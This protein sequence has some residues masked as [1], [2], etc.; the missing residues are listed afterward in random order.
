MT[1]PKYAPILEADEVRP[2]SR[3]APPRAWTPHR[4]GEIRPGAR[5]SG[6]GLGDPGPDQGYALGLA[7]RF[8]DRLVLGAGERRDD[9]LAGAVA[10]AMRRAASFGRAP[11]S[12]DLEVALGLFG[13]FGEAPAELLE[14]RRALFAGASH[15]YWDQREL[16][17][18]VPEET[19]RLSP[20]AVRAEPE[21]WRALLGV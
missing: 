1:Q 9:V 11:V 17:Q 8:S 21:N 6:R 3:L 7:E 15:D 14:R 20:A 13:F 16:A 4:P 5:P 18:S 19:L 12:A 10:L 2:A